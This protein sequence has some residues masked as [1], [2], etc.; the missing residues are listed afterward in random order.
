MIALIIGGYAWKEYHRANPDVSNLKTDY[1]TTA[2]QL[3]GEFQQDESS[4]DKK[5]LGKIILVRGEL[6]LVEK[7]ADGFYTVVIG[8]SGDPSSIRCAMDSIHNSD[9]ASL[10]VNSSI[11][12]KGIVTGFNKDE[13]GLGSDIILT[14]SVVVR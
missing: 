6:K 4:A 2:Q 3:L 14:R 1:E 5:Y 10:R 13:L 9:A 7:D 12:M 11:K 8:E